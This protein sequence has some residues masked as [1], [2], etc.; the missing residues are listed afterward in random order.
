M[1]CGDSGG[2]ADGGAT[3]P[4]TPG[5][6]GVGEWRTG[7]QVA[8]RRMASCEGDKREGGMRRTHTGGGGGGGRTGCGAPEARRAS[9]AREAR[10]RADG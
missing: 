3:R 9:A 4:G 7:G 2:G 8:M 5:G 6:A 10:D 1:T